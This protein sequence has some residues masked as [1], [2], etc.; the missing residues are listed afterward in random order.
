M[1]ENVFNS[2]VINAVIEQERL[3]DRKAKAWDALV[4]FIDSGPDF[5]KLSHE[6]IERQNAA[7]GWKARCLWAEMEQS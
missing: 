1:A 5:N 6:S 3:R 7:I 2:D 4:D